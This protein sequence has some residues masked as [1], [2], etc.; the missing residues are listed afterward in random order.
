MNNFNESQRFKLNAHQFCYIHPTDSDSSA[1][2]VILN[3]QEEEVYSSEVTGQPLG[4]AIDGDDL[5]LGNAI[6][7]QNFPSELISLNFSANPGQ[8]FKV[9]QLGNTARYGGVGI[10]DI[11]DAGFRVHRNTHLYYLDVNPINIWF[12][13]S[14]NLFNTEIRDRT[15]HDGSEQIWYEIETK[16]L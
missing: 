5:L 3:D 4:L 2:F 15:T 6:F 13:P 9:K 12:D 8:A 16:L 10:E 1:K 7:G 11:R 14:T